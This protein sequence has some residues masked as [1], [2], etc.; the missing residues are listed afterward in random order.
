MTSV[1]VVGSINVDLIFSAARLPK[2]GETIGDAEFAIAPGGKGANQA[3]AARRMG[4]DVTMVGCVGQDVWA[5][6][7]LELLRADD[8]VLEVES[9][10]GRQTGMA[11]IVVAA[12]GENQI[13]VAPGANDALDATRV[14]APAAD[15]L[16]CQLEVPTETV[17]TVSEHFAGEVII[18]AAPAA[19]FVPELLPTVGTL[20]V[21]E[22]EYRLLEGALVAFEGIIITTLGSDGAVATQNGEPIARSQP[23]QVEPI[24][25]V[26]AG[27]AFCGAY[28]VA[29]GEGATIESAL[30]LAVTAGSLATTKAGAQPSLPTREE[31]LGAAFGS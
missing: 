21:N 24:D 12:D 23:P 6:P 29:V 3:L 14:K 10:E 2:P 22:S 28:A 8:V 7:A 9:L 17:L 16:L 30:Q 1:T 20:I 31:V 26:G 18:N 15:V 27:D 4:A 5:D 11:M 19:P 13:V 25:T